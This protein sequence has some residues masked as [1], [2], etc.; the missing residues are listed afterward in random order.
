MALLNFK[1]GKFENLASV[2]KNAGTVYITKD[3]K[4]MY[5]DIDDSTRIRIGDIIQLNS[6]REAQPPFSTEALYYFIEENALLKWVQYAEDG[7]TKYKWQQL[8]SVSD[9]QT[10]ISDL[11]N[12][13]A[14]LKTKVG[15]AATTDSEG[16]PVAATGLFADVAAL[17]TADTDLQKQITANKT[18]IESND[19]DIADLTERMVAAE[20]IT[21][22]VSGIAEQA[23]ENKTAIEKVSGVV[24]DA[25]TA[26][27]LV[28]RTDAIEKSIG[29]EES[30][31]SILYRVKAVETLA[32]ENKSAI[33]DDNTNGTVKNRIKLLEDGLATT[34]TTVG[35]HTTT[36]ADHE[37]AISELKAA[38]GED[39]SGLAGK[40]DSLTTD[41][42][43]AKSD[44][45]DIQTKN[46]EQDTAI[47]DAAD[48][49]AANKTAIEKLNGDSTVEGS[50]AYAVAA[51]AE[52]RANAD[53]GLQ[54]SI[55][56][57][58]SRVSDIE[59]KNGEQDT[60]IGNAAT[61]AAENKTAIEKLTDGMGES[62][63]ILSKINEAKEALSA[64]IDA[65]INA[66]NAMEYQGNISSMDDLPI[67]GVKVGDT[68]VVATKFSSNG[69]TYNA[70]DML[71]AT[72]TEDLTTGIIGDDL[73]WN[74]VKT[75]YDVANEAHLTGMDNAIN[76]TSHL[77]DEAGD[78][79]KITFVDGGSGIKAT[80]V[81]GVVTLTMEWGT[82]GED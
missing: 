30:E 19:T 80:V 53:T 51:E 60:A 24:G 18:A 14:T 48:Q 3:E 29:T 44:I 43:T 28:Y 21:V 45:T 10:N 57:L 16:Q 49:A 77:S 61:Q 37:D 36:L 47:K 55:N 63:T 40:I 59:T 65:D 41:L 73:A 8:N 27:S 52:L 31:S 22:T 70:G 5:V 42:N 23:A 75:G 50:V 32:G 69:I 12:D 71:I 79:G 38:V 33:G 1:L 6:V 78:L 72:G 13:V 74:H 54:N 68:Y 15:S 81:D 64:E 39:A 26:G 82:F 66:A 62:D 35:E 34:N 11:Q 67:S 9:L 20:A 25:S 4:A 46:S 76:L 56:S 7:Q 17:Q 58:A 2:N